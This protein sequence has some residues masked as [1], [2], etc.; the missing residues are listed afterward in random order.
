MK[1]VAGNKHRIFCFAA[2]ILIVCFVFCAFLAIAADAN[3]LRHIK[4]EEPL[5]SFS[6]LSLSG[7]R[8]VVV[9]PGNEKPAVLLVFALDSEFRR[10]RS[11]ALL[12]MLNTMG[13]KYGGKV[14]FWGIL[15]D[16]TDV[17]DLKNFIKKNKI[18]IPVFDDSGRD[19]YNQYGVF[20]MP[21]IIVASSAG[22]LQEVIP[23]TSNVG[24][25][26][27]ANIMVALGKWTNEEFEHAIHPTNEK[28]TSSEEE[29][30]LRK[31]NYG[32]VMAS[33]KMYSQAVREFESAISLDRNKIE[34][35]IELGYIRLAQE[36]WSLA[37][38]AF[39][40]ALK[41]EEMDDAVAGHGLALYGR[42][43]VDAALAELKDAALSK[44]PRVEVFI[45]LAEIYEK[46]GNSKESI[47]LYKEAVKRLMIMYKHGWK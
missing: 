29:T 32:R 13:Q 43:D 16:D 20:V 40:E 7:G 38:K 35:Y 22:T 45:A 28:E 12:S 4:K 41:R 17:I 39:G 18:A 3:S 34:G 8:P 46:K 5:P 47:R 26:V 31:L 21:V 19:F 24:E 23:Y 37:E 9:M 44:S 36:E 6:L 10:E 30:Y 25:L 27:E 15:S 33:R 1:M 14:D 11:L 42:G 2:G